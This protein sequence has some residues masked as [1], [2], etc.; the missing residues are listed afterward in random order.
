MEQTLTPIEGAAT[1]AGADPTPS[2][3]ASLHELGP[4]RPPQINRLMSDLVAQSM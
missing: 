3:W 4:L 1:T 2:V